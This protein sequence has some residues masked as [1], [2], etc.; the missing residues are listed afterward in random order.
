MIRKIARQTLRAFKAL[1]LTILSA[2]ISAIVAGV[3]VGSIAIYVLYRQL[4]P[5][6]ATLRPE[7]I[8]QT[9]RIYDRS[10]QHILYE[11]YGEENR[12]IVGYEGIA[13]S[14][15]K[16]TV[17]A[18]DERFYSHRGVD[19]VAVLRAA[20][21]NFEGGGVIEG[22]STI[23]MQLSRNVFF[24][25]QKTYERKI[26]EAVTALKIERE[27]S[28]E[29][30]LQWY[31]NIVPYG[32]NAYG[33][34]AASQVYFGKD[35]SELTLDES[36][37][38]ASLPK[39]TTYYSPYGSHTKELVAR[40]RAILRKMVE[41]NLVSESE[42][43]VALAEDTL[44]KVRPFRQHIEAPHFVMAVV[45]ELKNTL[46][47]EVL[48][49]GGLLIRTTLDYDMQKMGE[50]VVKDGVARNSRY[51]ASNGALVAMDPKKGEVLT[52]VGSRD[53]FDASIDGQVNVAMRP[54]QPG[55]SFKPIAYAQ[56]FE[57]GFQPETIVYDVPT[58]FGPDG[59][60][61]DYIPQNYSGTFRGPVTLRQALAGSLNIPAVKVLYLAGVDSTIDLA[62]RLGITTLNE[63]NRYGLA[64]VLG[65]G[66]ITL[67]DGVSAFSVF[68]NDGIR[69]PAHTVLEVRTSDNKLVREER[70]VSQQV[71]SQQTARKISSIL[72]DN[73]ARS[74]VFGSSSSLSIP[75]RTVA[76]K[77]GTTQ[78]FRDAWTIGYTP[79]LAVGVWTGN[80]DNTM[81]RPG[82]DGSYVAAPIWNDFMRQ[83]LANMPNETFPDYEKI[84]S[85]IPMVTRP[86][87][88]RV[89]YYRITSGKEVSEETANNL[90]PEKVRRKVEGEGRD[91]LYYLN[92]S[93][94]GDANTFPKYG[95][96]MRARWDAGVR[97]I[98]PETSIPDDIIE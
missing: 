49:R 35:A 93:E 80:N 19:P 10:G 88:T 53:Y 3:I 90:G 82:S 73:T 39:A 26:A 81:M 78:E 51:N 36:A 29:D 69:V 50:Q 94:Y 71:V 17:A 48:N 68:A 31:L 58:N 91:I 28:K 32:S 77:T 22:G 63:R 24:S 6:I 8:S 84:E 57:L 25:R 97:G 34:Q 65:G 30:I 23:T 59:S 70:S 96:D 62:H 89:S 60:G 21:A 13:D 61:S 7:N 76:V 79:S 20:R 75:E 33:A 45:E 12:T 55:S 66:E 92:S 15:R 54:R 16:A 18:E 41:L 4:T 72:S 74:A 95:E 67:L 64:L 42:I 43:Q 1:L 85:P 14:L 9:S 56:A 83:S 86:T 47:E 40:Q 98:P 2:G 27:M 38:I 87:E 11:L 46:G 52:M 44:A 5:D 37:L